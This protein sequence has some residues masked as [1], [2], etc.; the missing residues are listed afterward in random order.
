ML[1]GYVKETWRG[2]GQ[3]QVTAW[4]TGAW[5]HWRTLGVQGQGRWYVYINPHQ[6]LR[7][8]WG[9]G[10]NPLALPVCPPPPGKSAPTPEG[11]SVQRKSSGKGTAVGHWSRGQWNGKAQGKMAERTKRLCYSVSTFAKSFARN[12]C[13]TIKSSCV[14]KKLKRRTQGS[15]SVELKSWSYIWKQVT[16]VQVKWTG[17]FWLGSGFCL[18]Q[19]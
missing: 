5:S 9:R 2:W 6:S 3:L 17:A 10:L 13:P 1:V 18:W 4:V 19:L 11:S 15:F 7:T 12:G 8:S 16:V 14:W